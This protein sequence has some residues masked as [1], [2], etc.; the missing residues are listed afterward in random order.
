MKRKFFKNFIALCI[1]TNETR[2]T[3][4]LNQLKKK[5]ELLTLSKVI[6]QFG[7]VSAK[8]VRDNSCLVFLVTEIISH[9]CLFNLMWIITNS[10]F[11]RSR[12]RVKKKE[13]HNRNVPLGSFHIVD[14]RPHIY[15]LKLLLGLN[16]GA[17]KRNKNYETFHGVMT[18]LLLLVSHGIYACSLQI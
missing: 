12:I 7:L 4:Q 15:Q 8:T 17:S 18:K 6:L 5:Q 9:E 16:H 11:I 1:T 2:S 14:F 10:N 13:T 3:P